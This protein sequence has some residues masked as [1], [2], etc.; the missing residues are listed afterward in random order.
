MEQAGQGP[1]DLSNQQPTQH[2][3]HQFH[4]TMAAM[5]SPPASNKEAAEYIVEE[6]RQARNKM[7]TYPGLEQFRL[8]DK[9]GE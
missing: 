1:E 2:D 4:Q 7:P 6:E 8:V 5:L 3:D 9:M